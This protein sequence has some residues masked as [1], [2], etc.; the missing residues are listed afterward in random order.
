[1]PDAAATLT[2]APPALLAH[3]RDRRPDEPYGRE[4]I[5]LDRGLPRLVV[6]RH[7]GAALP[8]AGVVDQDVEAAPAVQNAANDALARL[9]CRHIDGQRFGLD[10]AGRDLVGDRLQVHLAAGAEGEPRALGGEGQGAGAAEAARGTGDE[11]DA[12]V[13]IEIHRGLTA[14]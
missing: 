11:D 14:L 13:E 10:P 6:E 3:R 5:Q 4:E 1:L 7:E 12:V 8:R 9:G 2:I